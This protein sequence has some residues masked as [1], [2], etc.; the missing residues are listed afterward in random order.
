MIAKRRTSERPGRLKWQVLCL[1]LPLAILLSY[2]P[3]R[4]QDVAHCGHTTVADAWGPKMASKAE[5]FL[6]RLQHIVRTK[7]KKKFASLIHYPV[8]VFVKDHEAKISS[9]S[10]FLA[11]Y[12]S[13]VTRDVRHALLAQTAD[14]LFGNWQGMMI[15]DGE[16]WFYPESDGQ[17]RIISI[18]SDA[19]RGDKK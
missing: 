11:K 6:A 5:A 7:D 8:L 18:I 10:A 13:I 17:M 2:A 3:C 1:A 4:A 15:G 19:P 9:R 16:V 12:S 14:C